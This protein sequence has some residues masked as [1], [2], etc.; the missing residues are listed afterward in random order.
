MA[1]ALGQRGYA[2]TLAEATTQLGGRVMRE[3]ALPTLAEWSRVRDWRVTQLNKLPNAEVFLDSRLDA[4]Q[5][6]E[7]G[8]DRVVL[9]TGATWRRSGVGRA[10]SAGIPGHERGHEQLR[11]LQ[12]LMRLPRSRGQSSIRQ[13]SGNI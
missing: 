13:L 10:H 2:V 11:H 1:R 4:Q 9:A 8:A 6:L 5:I 3:A 12:K 7:F